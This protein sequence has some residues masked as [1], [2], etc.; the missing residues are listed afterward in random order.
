MTT[1]AFTQE[2]IENADFRQVAQPSQLLVLPNNCGRGDALVHMSRTIPSNEY[3]LP[4]YYIRSDMLD[5]PRIIHTGHV[6]QDVVDSAAELLSYDDGYPTLQSGSPYW[7]QMP[8]EPHQT[9]LLFQ[10]YLDLAETEGIRLID[11][12]ARLEHTPLDQVRQYFQEFYWSSRARAYDLF[13]VAADAKRREVRTRKTENSHYETAG[14]FLAQIAGLITEDKLNEMD[15]KGLLDALES[16]VKIQRL[17]LGL[18]GQ[19]ASTVNRDMSPASS[20]E[21]ILRQLTKNSGPEQEG[22]ESFQSRLALLMTDEATAMQAQE[23]IVR[24]TGAGVRNA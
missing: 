13:I 5:L 23:L 3:G 15:A 17:S 7:S 6:P 2:E 20:V 9:Y 16:M 11:S 10:R 14:K 24:A 1:V 19:N 12:L 18:T 8:H 4:L 21:V 22:A